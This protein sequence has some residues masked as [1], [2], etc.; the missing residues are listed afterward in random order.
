MK[1]RHWISG[2]LGRLGVQLGS[3]T[4]GLFAP[5]R[6]DVPSIQQGE[7]KYDVRPPL[8]STA[9]WRMIWSKMLVVVGPKCR[10]RAAALEEGKSQDWGGSR[11]QRDT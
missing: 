10:P 6:D 2:S 8:E 3:P 11:I 7:A 5:S 1:I 4:G 9:Q